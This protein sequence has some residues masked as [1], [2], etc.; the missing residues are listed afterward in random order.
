[1]IGPSPKGRPAVFYHLK[2]T[3]LLLL[4][5][6]CCPGWMRSSSQLLCP[7]DTCQRQRNP[8]V[9]IKKQSL[10]KKRKALGDACPI[11]TQ[12]HLVICFFKTCIMGW[13]VALLFQ[14]YR[15]FTKSCLCCHSGPSAAARLGSTTAQQTE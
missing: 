1:M 2:Q 3:A 12:V 15:N 4:H 14:P 13:G 9:L 11:L 5:F 8:V 6:L 7:R 10:K